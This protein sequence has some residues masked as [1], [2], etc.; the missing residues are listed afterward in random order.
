LITALQGWAT[1]V[2]H[3]LPKGATYEETLE[4]LEDRFGDQHLAPA[5]RNQLKT[6]TQRVGESLQGFSTA[7]E[8]LAHRD[9]PAL[10]EDHIR[11][12]AGKTFA[13]G[14]ED[15]DV[16]IQLLLGGEKTVNEALRQ[17]LHEHQE[18]LGEPIAPPPHPAKSCKTIGVLELWKL[19]HF[20]GTCPYGRESESDQR[21]KRD[22][23]PPRDNTG[24][25]KKVRVL[26]E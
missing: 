22:V 20:R 19:G 2:L 26:T 14:V 25:A 21:G 7:I 24:T 4:A 13:D 12:E 8:Q 17:A 1:D 3:G 23:R 18:I 9:Y 6:R 16:K 10:P 11:G 5:Y 15:P